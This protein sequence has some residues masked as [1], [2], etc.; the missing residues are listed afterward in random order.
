MTA[1]AINLFD[2]IPASEHAGITA[3]TSSH[4]CDT[5]LSAAIA[6]LPVAGG[7]IE[8]GAG[9]F[10]F[11]DTINLK[12][13]LILDGVGSGEAGAKASVLSFAPNKSGVV[14]N[15]WNTLGGGLEN[16][17]TGAGDASI[18]RNLALVS[19]GGTVGHGAWMRA[20]GE[21]SNVSIDGFGGNGIHIVADSGSSDP[22][23]LGNAN[24]W[25]VSRVRIV[26]C[27]HGMYVEGG[28]TNAGTAIAVDVSN[29]RG[30]GIW[31]YSFLGNSYFGC[32]AEANLLGP[33]KS[34]GANAC[35]EF[36][37]CYSE[38]G[39]PPSSL[40]KPAAV[41]GGM[42]AAGITG[43]A[44]VYGSGVITPFTAA[45]A[46]DKYPA[47]GTKRTLETRVAQAGS[48]LDLVASGDH[49]HGWGVVWQE[50]PKTIQLKHGRSD[51]RVAFELTTQITGPNF[52]DEANVPLGAGRL[53]MQGAWVWLNP[54]FR[55]IDFR[56]QDDAIKSLLARVAVLE[57]AP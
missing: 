24:N 41:W 2:F 5:D 30:W 38:S 1:T 13:T 8:F 39:Q 9:K 34:N 11:A 35:N 54:R 28:D 50:V 16:P 37:G 7:R 3:Q 12:K 22:A 15:R 19:Q 4:P 31:D 17:T 33:Y 45:Q 26:G 55:Y 46:V 44:A 47:D 53:C 52:V 14:F 6:S 36:F 10:C 18:V 21:V 23:V 57:A 29:N 32:H 20:R 56:A 40:M 51:A 43:T 48:F 49:V 27:N 25:M 42:H